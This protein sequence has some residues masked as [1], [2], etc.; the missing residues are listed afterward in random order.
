MSILK[1]V[2]RHNR[3]AILLWLIINLLHL[4]VFLLYRVMM[5]PMLYAL[6]LS[7]CLLAVILAADTVK[8]TARHRERQRAAQSVVRDWKNLPEAQS[9]AEEDYQA[10]IAALGEQLE[11][12]LADYS[13]QQQDQLDYYTAWV[14]QIKTPIAVMKL[15]LSGDTPVNR[16]LLGELL[17]IEQ[18]A[19]MVL[20]Y[21]RLGSPSHDLVIR[22]YG[23]DE[24]IRD[25][26][27][28]FAPQFVERKLRLEYTPVTQKVVTD[29]KWFGCI[30]E[31]LISNA[32]KY[33]PSGTVSIEVR[34][35]RLTVADTG[36]GIA[37]E[38]LPR[39][40]EKGYT[41]LNGRT[42]RKSS[43]LGLYLAKKA[44]DLL[45]IPLSV[46][47]TVGEGSRFTLAIRHLEP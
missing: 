4:T 29:Q 16:L 13:A 17:R 14:H 36:I 32:V 31:Q 38:D 35:G 18:Y 44:A 7:F 20:Q 11:K 47:S 45:N 27:R 1:E 37:A 28:R 15:K 8:E 23:L 12:H 43:G 42:A 34:D 6:F 3:S 39:I 46:E 2:L 9:L 25:A 40:F 33:T 24:L 21:I 19:D 5:E 30:L 26:V 22:E 41:G 10:M